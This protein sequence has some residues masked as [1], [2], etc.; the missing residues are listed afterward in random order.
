M[1]LVN[2]LNVQ[3]FVSYF[4]INFLY[5][6]HLIFILYKKNKK[7]GKDYLILGDNNEDNDESSENNFKLLKDNKYKIILK[8]K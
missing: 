2:L 1:F 3:D 5:F 6:F 8:K 7:K 4:L